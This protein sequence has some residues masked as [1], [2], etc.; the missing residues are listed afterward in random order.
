MTERK[1]PGVSFQSWV[2]KQINDA[3]A[4]GDFDNL[5]GAGKPLENLDQP[6]D[7]VW[8]M[9]HMQREGLPTED[10]LPTPL[11]LR[12]EIERLPDTVRDLRTEQAVRDVVAE[13]NARILDWLR[14]PSGP[15]VNVAPVD[16]DK[17]VGRWH[18]ARAAKA[19]PASVTSGTPDASTAP[20]LTA[21]AMPSPRS[22]WWHRFTRR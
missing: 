10:L 4:R 3:V 16:V 15:A 9:R 14:F 13:L 22:R 19:A 7:E 21:A 12:K 18:S 11:R 1:P 5:P 17:V 2:D 6:Y 20:D 8:V